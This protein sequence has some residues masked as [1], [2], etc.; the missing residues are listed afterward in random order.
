MQCRKSYFRCNNALP[1]PAVAGLARHQL[2]VE[3]TSVASKSQSS[4]AVGLILN[5][6]GFLNDGIITACMCV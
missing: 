2:T 6:R 1:Y 3:A 5:C 4:L